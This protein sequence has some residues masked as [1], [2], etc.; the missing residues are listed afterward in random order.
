MYLRNTMRGGHHHPVY[1]IHNE[2]GEVYMLYFI[3]H[4]INRARAI[5]V[6]ADYFSI[7]FSNLPSSSPPLHN[8]FI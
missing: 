2:S 6:V 5:V 1:S 7:F 3:K 8:I 4:T